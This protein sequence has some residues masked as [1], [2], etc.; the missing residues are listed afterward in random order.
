MK[1]A[2]Q[3]ANFRIKINMKMF[4]QGRKV[5]DWQDTVKA[6]EN[7]KKIDIIILLMGQSMER[8]EGL[9]LR[10]SSLRHS[11]RSLQRSSRQSM[12]FDKRN[13][14]SASKLQFDR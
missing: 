11:A 4:L 13:S 1:I 10:Q 2:K 6:A 12:G 3:N 5:K 7:C 14:Y 8:P 9:T